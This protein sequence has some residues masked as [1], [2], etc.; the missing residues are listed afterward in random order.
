[1]R[2]ITLVLGVVIALV[3][4]LTACTTEPG[5]NSVDD[6]SAFAVS[7]TPEA[8][9]TK[10]KASEK[11]SE[12]QAISVVFQQQRQAVERA[13]PE[14]VDHEFAQELLRLAL[15]FGWDFDTV[16]GL[17]AR[18][19]GAVLEYRVSAEQDFA[20]AIYNINQQASEEIVHAIKGALNGNNG[21][22]NGGDVP[23]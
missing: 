3:A 8:S 20:D 5:N 23:N 4:T 17:Y 12:I 1:M 15:E 7:A 6:I 16:W 19:L 9:V 14:P 13:I 22:L 21:G 18:F 11:I 2:V 10:S